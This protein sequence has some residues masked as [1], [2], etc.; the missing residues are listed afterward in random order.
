MLEVWDQRV[1]R[2]REGVWGR[3]LLQV[4]LLGCRWSSSPCVFTASS[5]C[6]CLCPNFPFYKDSGHNALDPPPPWPHL[7]LVTSIKTLTQRKSHSKVLVIRTSAYGV[8][9]RGHNSIHNRLH[10][11]LWLGGIISSEGPQVWIWKGA[12]SPPGVWESGH[13]K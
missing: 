7:N 5:L 9:A 1:S 6:M 3:G 11:E 12:W 10:P 13:T 8:G 2:V 4:S